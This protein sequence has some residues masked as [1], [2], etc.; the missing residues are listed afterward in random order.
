[1]GGCWVYILLT[2]IQTVCRHIRTTY[3]G[4]LQLYGHRNAYALQMLYN[5]IIHIP[6]KQYWNPENVIVMLVKDAC[7]LK[8]D[9]IRVLGVRRR[10]SYSYMFWWSWL[11]IGHPLVPWTS[12][13][14]NS[15]TTKLHSAHV[16]MLQRE[17]KT[18]RSSDSFC[19]ELFSKQPSSKL[20]ELIYSVRGLVLVCLTIPCPN[21]IVRSPS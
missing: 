2:L 19:S 16:R 20:Q 11:L 14:H 6:I 1:M 5:L 12:R 10:V 7:H 13:R 4:G 15:M 9:V 8:I 21:D 17:N 18:P 3:K